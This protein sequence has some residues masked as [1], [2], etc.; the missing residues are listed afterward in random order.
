MRQARPSLRKAGRLAPARAGRLRHLLVFAVPGLAVYA[1]FVLVPVVM[2]VYLSLT[3]QNAFNPP[4]RFIGLANYSRLLADESFLNALR[5]TAVITVLVTAGANACGLCIALLLERRG[6][7]NN[8][9][10]SVFFTPVVL[11]SVVVSVIWQALLTDDGL[12]NSLLTELG[13]QQPPGWLSDPGIALYSL[14]WI[15]CWQVLGFCV[16]V[17]LAALQGI[18][19][20]LH[21]AAGLDGA[22]PLE[23]FRHVTWPMIAPAVTINTIMLLITG[24][25]VYDQVQVITNGGPGDGAT[26]TIAFEIV[27]TA[28]A[29]NR[30]G[31]ASAMATVMLVLVATISTVVLRALQRREVSA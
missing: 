19:Q 25:K 21:E 23:R 1:L 24:F 10:R 7:L 30:V 31:Y 15:I 22:G 26:S 27:Q 11:S 6:W 14:S 8:I 5:N 3:N 28:F 9:L 13:V 29:G 4:T 20:E 18:P 17:Y 12:L 16:V 2:T